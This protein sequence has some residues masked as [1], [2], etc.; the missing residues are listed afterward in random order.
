MRVRKPL[1]VI[2]SL[3]VVPCKEAS[4][5]S[6]SGLKSL[7]LDRRRRPTSSVYRATRSENGR[8]GSEVKYRGSSSYSTDFVPKMKAL[9]MEYHC[10]VSSKFRR[11]DV[12]RALRPGSARLGSA[13]GA[14]PPRAGF[15]VVRILGS[16]GRLQGG[17]PRQGSCSNHR[18]RN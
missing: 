1:S 6:E 9:L 17:S 13:R 3:A 12:P 5:K 15:I 10:L 7:F 4:L 8:N 16:T 11:R 14:A 2:T 18:R